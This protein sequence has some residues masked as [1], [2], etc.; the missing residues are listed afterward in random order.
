MRHIDPSTI[1]T[2]EVHRYLLACVAPRPIAFVS[3]RSS[4]GRTNLAPFSFFNAFGANPPVVAFSPAYRGT[5]G[6]S[7]HTLDNVVETGEFAVSIVSHSMV[8]QMSLASADWPRE[9]NEFEAAGFTE[10]PSD[11][12]TPPGVAE[13][14]MFMECS[15]IHN[16]SLGDGPGSGNLIVGEV[17]MF[18]IKESVFVGKYPDI[19]RLDLVARMGGP[20][21]CRAS[22]DAV[23]TLAKPQGLGVGFGGL[24]QEVR[25]SGVLSANDA[26]ILASASDLPSSEESDKIL[27]DANAA[28]AAE[29]F[30][31]LEM[32]LRQ[33]STDELLA[34]ARRGSRGEVD[35]SVETKHEVVHSLLRARS[36]REAW[37]VLTADG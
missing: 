36:V 3:T 29:R 22:G 21:Y 14:P 13:S 28:V 32:I 23:F 10:H 17:K 18:H 33:G 24:P 27:E 30:D 4:D 25:E 6:S 5:D 8:E 26:A 2:S 7:K 1:P 37:A 20:H 11:L 16:L 31:D 15:V 9:T 12:I 34:L 35:W 19:E